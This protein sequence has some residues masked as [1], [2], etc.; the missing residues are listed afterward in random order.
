MKKE[1]LA[2]IIKNNNKE[3]D[4]SLVPDEF[5]YNDDLQILVQIFSL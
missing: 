3:Y 1:E 4:L 2:D 5:T